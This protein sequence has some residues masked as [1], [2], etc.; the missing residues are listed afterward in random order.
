ME[1]MDA[2]V[3]TLEADIK[4]LTKSIDALTTQVQELTASMNRGKGA[5]GF[6]VI[7]VG[8]FAALITKI[9]DKVF[10]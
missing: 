9:V 5:F 4:H 2:K 7:V 10:Q 6:A 3:A 1:G 8:G